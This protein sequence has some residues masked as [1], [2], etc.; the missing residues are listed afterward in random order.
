MG[1]KKLA[2]ISASRIKTLQTCS[3][4]FWLK[5]H[6]KVPDTPN[7]GSIRGTVCHLILELLLKIKH[8]K[9]FTKIISGKAISDSPAINRLVIKSLNSR[10]AFTQENYDLCD[11]MIRVGLATDFFGKGGKV[12]PPEKA[13][14]IEEHDPNYIIHGFIDKI[15]LFK[16]QKVIKIIDYK[17]SKYKFRGEELSTNIQAM[18]YSL[19]A[20]EL[21]PDYKPIVQF[22]FLRFPKSP[23]Q[24]L[25]Y[26]NEQLDGLKH[27]LGHVYKVMQEFTLKDAESSF[28][29][30]DPASKWMCGIGKWVCPCKKPFDYFVLLDKKKKVLK[31]SFEDDFETKKGQKVEK[32]HYEGCPKF[33]NLTGETRN[34]DSVFI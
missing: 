14:L 11:K 23:I 12:E 15:V 9:H 32:R 26:S 8:K 2:Y 13:F 1:E 5:Y 31:S 34:E 6:V 27:Y 18:M 29:I 4:L 25:E 16:R 17:S 30:D 3:W 7:D 28:A 33:N 10:K 22:V 24:Q 21:W 20:R 19:A